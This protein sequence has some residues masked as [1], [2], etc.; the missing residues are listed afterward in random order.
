MWGLSLP[1]AQFGLKPHIYN[2]FSISPG[3]P[4]SWLA[5][6]VALGMLF[7][8]APWFGEQGQ[9]VVIFMLIHDLILTFFHTKILTHHTPGKQVREWDVVLV[10]TPSRADQRKSTSSSSMVFCLKPLM[11]FRLKASN[12]VWFQAASF[13]PRLAELSRMGR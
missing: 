2:F 7:V 10:F 6:A 9:A 12:F 11:V 3:S 4:V 8:V 5:I 13:A 1:G